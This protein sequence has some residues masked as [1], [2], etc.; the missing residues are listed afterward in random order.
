MSQQVAKA[1]AGQ[2]NIA[3]SVLT[4]LSKWWLEWIK[5]KPFAFEAIPTILA[6]ARIVRYYQHP[7]EPSND[8]ETA[9]RPA[10]DLSNRTA[11]RPKLL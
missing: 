8:D 6:P 7:S 11:A 1:A 3:A 10:G 4:K 9:Q 5:S 2:F